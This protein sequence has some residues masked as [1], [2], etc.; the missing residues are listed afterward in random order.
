MRAGE[1]RHRV[2]VT[3]Q[4]ETD[5]GH[6]GT[7][8][9]PVIVCARVPAQVTPL[10]GRELDQA[11]QIDPRST[12]QVRLRYRTDVKAGQTVTY[13]DDRRG[14]RPFEIVAPPQDM[15]ELHRDLHL[16]CREAA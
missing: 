4:T 3:G 15:N 7:Q 6:G 10:S 1:L 5:D 16:L 8:Y 9:A 13:H 2:T 14:D 11:Q 12:H